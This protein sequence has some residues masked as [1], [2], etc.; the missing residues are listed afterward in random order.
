L[1]AKKV[2]TDSRLMGWILLDEQPTRD[3]EAAWGFTRST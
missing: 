1:V 3:R 2:R